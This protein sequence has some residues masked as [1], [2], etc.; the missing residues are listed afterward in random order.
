MEDSGVSGCCCCGNDIISSGISNSTSG[1]GMHSFVFSKCLRLRLYDVPSLVRTVYD[2]S[3]CLSVTTAC[4]HALFCMRAEVPISS[5]ASGFV[6]L[7]K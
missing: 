7:S 5:G 3:L 4:C 2:L 6:L 1:V